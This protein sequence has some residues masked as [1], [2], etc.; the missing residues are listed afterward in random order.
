M[1][2]N[3]LQ[4]AWHA[5]ARQTLLCL[6]ILGRLCLIPDFQAA[7]AALLLQ[8]H[9]SLVLIPDTSPMAMGSMEMDALY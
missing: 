1:S 2:L 6:A 4:S 5:P 8:W 3:G 9:P 7:W